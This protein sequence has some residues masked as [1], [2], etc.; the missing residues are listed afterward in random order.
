M[1]IGIIAPCAV[2]YVLGGAEKLW[3]GLERYINEHTEHVAD[4]IKLPSREQDLFGLAAGYRA[5]GRLDLSGFD[6][7]VSGKYPAWGARH[8]CHCVYLQHKL[9]GLYDSYP[10]AIDIPAQLRRLPAISALL[11]LA[12]RVELG[13]ADVGD[14]LD[15]II[16]LELDEDPKVRA[17]GCIPGPL[18]RRMVHVI[19]NSL[20]SP[21]HIARYAAISREVAGRVAYFAPQVT[22]KVLHPP[23]SVPVRRGD[24]FD[25]LFTAS[26]LDGPKRIELLIDAM[27]HSK[28]ELVLKIAGGGPLMDALRARAEGDARIQFLGHVSENELIEL[29]ADCLAVL[30]VPFKEDYGLITLEAMLAGKAVLTTSDAGGPGELVNHQS[31]GLIVPAEA[32]AI[33]RAID[34]LDQ[35]RERTVGFGKA[36]LAA[37]QRVTWQPVIDWLTVPA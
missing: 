32:P 24:R 29:Y 19:D 37:A 6:I 1:R 10:G 11:A 2:P 18:A 5:F 34:S 16:L 20:L 35:D 3:W 15:Q 26:R 22:V 4:V 21:Q 9:R 13:T 31:T 7:I 14:L 30:F 23:T 8:E 28:T 25:Y 36:G 12:D 33:A 27:R 17:A